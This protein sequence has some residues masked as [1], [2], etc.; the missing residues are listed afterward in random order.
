MFNTNEL[1]TIASLIYD[2]SAIKFDIVEPDIHD[3]MI[4]PYILKYV[5]E[6]SDTELE[7]LHQLAIHDILKIKTYYLG[8][9]TR[10]VTIIKDCNDLALKEYHT[11]HCKTQLELETSSSA[12]QVQTSDARLLYLSLFTSTENKFINILKNISDAKLENVFD[13]VA[14]LIK[15]NPAQH[16]RNT[17]EKKFNA[18]KDN[19][20]SLINE[21]LNRHKMKQFADNLLTSDEY[22]KN[23]K[24]V[25]PFYNRLEKEVQCLKSARANEAQL[26]EAL[27]AQASTIRD[28]LQSAHASQIFSCFARPGN[29]S[30]MAKHL[31]NVLK[32]YQS[33]TSTSTSPITPTKMPN[34]TNLFSAKS[35]VQNAIKPYDAKPDQAQDA[36]Q[37]RS[38]RLNRFSMPK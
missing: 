1:G 25:K 13:E 4:Q 8:L 36:D 9:K 34:T 24:K 31:N 32:T 5:G 26:A 37:L 7:C 16:S 12:T 17:L 19:Q 33:T 3:D 29:R 15:K 18:Y 21:K 22:D 20:R 38:T 2:V 6:L 10:S 27:Y 35:S 11:A 30:K 14:T 28:Q 23:R